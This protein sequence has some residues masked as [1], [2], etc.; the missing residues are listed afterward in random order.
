MLMS[1]KKILTQENGAN[2]YRCDLHVHTPLSSCYE[3]KSAS[4][5]DIIKKSKDENIR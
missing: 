3:D 2:F 4:L 1:V 5:E